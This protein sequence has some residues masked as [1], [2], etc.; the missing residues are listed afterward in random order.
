MDALLKRGYDRSASM[1]V[2]EELALG[3][4]LDWAVCMCAEDSSQDGRREMDRY[5]ACAARGRA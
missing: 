2:Q 3:S 1:S 5:R 4:R